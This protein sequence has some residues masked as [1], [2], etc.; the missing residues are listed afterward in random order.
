MGTGTTTYAEIKK[1]AENDGRLEIPLW[2]G[3]GWILLERS[4]A[5]G[6]NLVLFCDRLRMSTSLATLIGEWATGQRL[7]TF[8]N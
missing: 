7:P 4:E 5:V 8:H 6:R 2:S 3:N 1:A